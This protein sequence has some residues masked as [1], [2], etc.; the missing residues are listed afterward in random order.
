MMNRL[1]LLL[2][3]ACLLLPVSGIAQETLDELLQQVEQ[4]ASDEARIDQQ[5]LQEFRS[6]RNRQQQLLEEARAEL[7]A[8]Q[9]RSDRLNTEFDRWPGTSPPPS[10]TR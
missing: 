3:S 7:R 1:T 4:A 9:Q 8:Q 5:R 10:M 2:A 6:E